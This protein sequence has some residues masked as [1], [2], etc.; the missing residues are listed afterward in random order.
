MI[1]LSFNHFFQK[2]L[3]NFVEQI[4]KEY[5]EEIINPVIIMNPPPMFFGQN[6]KDYFENFTK[7]LFEK[8]LK[9][10]YKEEKIEEI[11]PNDENTDSK[12][13]FFKKLTSL[14]YSYKG[15]V[16]IS[17]GIVLIAITFT[18]KAYMINR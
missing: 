11:I 15:L 3:K 6:F 1:S 7:P 16:G 14:I 8:K 2:A 4:P 17:I 10:T 13:N 18:I 12:I 5:A 9:Y